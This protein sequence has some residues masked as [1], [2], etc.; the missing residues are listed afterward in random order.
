[1]PKQSSATVIAV[2]TSSSGS[3]PSIQ[4]RT[5]GSGRA[6]CELGEHVGIE[7]DQCPKSAARPRSVRA[8]TS[9]STA[10]ACRSRGGRREPTPAARL[11]RASTSSRIAACL[12][13]HRGSVA[14][15]SQPQPCLGF[16]VEPSDRQRSHTSSSDG[17][18]SNAVSGGCGSR[19]SEVPRRSE[20]S[21]P[22]ARSAITYQPR[23]GCPTYRPLVVACG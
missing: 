3:H 15:R 6:P 10:P 18:A 16:L 14:R 2:V 22:P 21:S 17:N 9:R 11:G 12:S 19:K 23:G 8:G 5:L 7:N 4:A 13:F 1:M 20:V